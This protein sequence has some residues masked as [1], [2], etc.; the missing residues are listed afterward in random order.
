LHL[1]VGS[2]VNPTEPAPVNAR[3][4]TIGSVRLGA[5]VTNFETYL[6]ASG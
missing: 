2:L 6:R 4:S 5:N 1:P 3:T